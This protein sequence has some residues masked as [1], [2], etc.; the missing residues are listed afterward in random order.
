MEQRVREAG[1]GEPDETTNAVRE[2]KTMAEG[3]SWSSLKQ[4][5]KQV[6]QINQEEWGIVIKRK[7]WEVRRDEE[8]L[9]AVLGNGTLRASRLPARVPKV[10]SRS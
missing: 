3:G 9:E 1:E 6:Q 4:I 5:K 7:D 10:M 2:C 8:V